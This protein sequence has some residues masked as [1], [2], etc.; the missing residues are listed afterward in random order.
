MTIKIKKVKTGVFASKSYDTDENNP[1]HGLPITI[2]V[3]GLDQNKLEIKINRGTDI[4]EWKSITLA[5]ILLAKVH[6]NSYVGIIPNVGG[7]DTHIATHND[8]VMMLDETYIS[9]ANLPNSSPI[10]NSLYFLYFNDVPTSMEDATLIIRTPSKR[11]ASDDYVYDGPYK[12][13]LES[14]GY[15]NMYTDLLPEFT[16]TASANTV[17]ADSH[18][19]VT[20]NV[21][22]GSLK[23][24]W[25]EPVCGI[26]NK[27]RVTITNN[28][29]K[30][31]LYSTGLEVGDVMRVKTGFRK[32][33][34]WESLTVNVV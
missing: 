7:D 31:K 12:T 3:L 24:V 11:D 33:Q 32:I 22:S 27:Q 6:E 21:T 25:I 10:W 5:E 34:G 13:Q 15:I 28:V 26:V 18:V 4:L 20:V 16:L 9:K 19:D 17:S 8:M 1:N 29:G 23:E 2:S 30:F 14:A